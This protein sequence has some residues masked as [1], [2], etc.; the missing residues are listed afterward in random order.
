MSNEEI[1]LIL[2]KIKYELIE[3]KER[4]RAVEKEQRLIRE[5][6]LSGEAKVRMQ[7][8]MLENKPSDRKELKKKMD[9]DIKIKI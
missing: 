8:R 9:E 7:K 1:L 4:L 3:I 6:I 5:D 2:E